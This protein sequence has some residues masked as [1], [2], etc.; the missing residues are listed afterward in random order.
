MSRLKWG[1]RVKR[2]IG[3]K[4]KLVSGIVATREEEEDGFRNSFAYK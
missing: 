4:L 2:E 3:M 1:H